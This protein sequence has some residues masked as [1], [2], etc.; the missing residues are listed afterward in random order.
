MRIG[1]SIAFWR[2]CS[3]FYFC[4]GSTANAPANRQMPIAS[5]VI[6]NLTKKTSMKKVLTILLFLVV[7]ICYGQKQIW[8]IGTAHEEKN[9]IN[10]DSLTYALN[11]IKPDLILIE[12]E[13]KYF[14]EDYQLNLE[15]YPDLLSTNENIASYKYQQLHTVELRPFEIDGR[16]EFYK[17]EN[18]FEKESQMFNEM[19]NL[20]EN[21]KLSANS[22][23]NFEIL[24]SALIS[25]ANVEF[26]SL[27]EANSDVATKFLALKNKINFEL[28]IS[29]VKQT[30]ELEKWL[31]FSELRKDFWDRRNKAMFEKISGYSKEY[32]DKKIVVLVGNDHKYFLLELLKQNEFEVKNYYE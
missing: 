2:L 31:E 17:R 4:S 20:Y 21:N 30:E 10:A 7:S 13:E 3:R 27:T 11:K 23:T 6:G 26:R 15:K 22:K 9:Y 5:V 14:T 12:L 18:Y 16:N 29:I 24:L 1:G 25:Y 19:L 32:P 8:L 28:M